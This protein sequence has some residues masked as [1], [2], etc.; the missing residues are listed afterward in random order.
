M[1]RATD[2]LGK[3][4]SG[5]KMKWREPEDRRGFYTSLLQEKVTRSV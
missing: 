2:A 4:E 5:K 1:K 3:K